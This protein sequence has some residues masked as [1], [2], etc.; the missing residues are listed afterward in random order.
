MLFGSAARFPLGGVKA[1]YLFGRLAKGRCL[2]G[3]GVAAF[4][5]GLAVSESPPA[6]FGECDCWVATPTPGWCI[7]R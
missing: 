7:C 5:D 1:D 2:A 3:A 6:G 4:F